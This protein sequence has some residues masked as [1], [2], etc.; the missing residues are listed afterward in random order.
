MKLIM[1][2]KSNSKLKFMQAELPEEYRMSLFP[3]SIDH[4]IPEFKRNST[5]G[6]DRVLVQNMIDCEVWFAEFVELIIS[7]RGKVFLPVCR[8]SDGEYMFILGE[9]PLDIRLP[10][11]VKARQWLGKLKHHLLLKGGIGA[12]TQGHYHSGEYSLNEWIQ[13]RREMPKLIRLLSEKGILALHLNYTCI[14]FQERY[15]PAL[16]SWLINNKIKIDA[17]NYYP[18]YFIY[19]LLNGSNSKRLYED[20]RI[21][22]VHGEQGNKRQ[23]II[24]GVLKRGARKV[25]W[26]SIS[27]KRSYFDIV[28][29]EPY[30]NKVDFC[31]VGAGIGKPAIL[32]QLEPLGVPCIDAGFAFEVL[33]D[34]NNK[35]ERAVS[36]TD[37]DWAD[38]LRDNS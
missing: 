30:K 2:M 13:A 6:R 21:L 5:A 15:F 19:A 29:V 17:S 35:W 12:F 10:F 8:L 24:D 14:P 23:R 4:I 11:R 22:I 7:N 25:Y 36:A 20:Q 38:R 32:L 26:C 27:L 18:F 34:E 33:A 31:L 1:I 37:S 28:D 9:Q 3:Y 16:N